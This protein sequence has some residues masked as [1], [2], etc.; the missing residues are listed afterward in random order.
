MNCT[1]GVL[2]SVLYY[3]LREDELYRQLENIEL[4][5]E[6]FLDE[7]VTILFGH[8]QVNNKR[9]SINQLIIWLIC[10]SIHSILT[11]ESFKVIIKSTY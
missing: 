6:S 7:L 10:R 8:V 9:K 5:F 11:L 3:L 1:W 4:E 2:Y